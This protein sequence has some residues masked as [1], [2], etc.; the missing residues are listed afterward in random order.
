MSEL[1]GLIF[2]L[3]KNP[4]LIAD[5]DYASAIR[6]ADPNTLA[7]LTQVFCSV[8]LE[9]IGPADIRVHYIPCLGA[10]IK[11]FC[12]ESEAITNLSLGRE[13]LIDRYLELAA[14]ATDE[15]DLRRWLFDFMTLGYTIRTVVTTLESGVAE[16]MSIANFQYNNLHYIESCVYGSDLYMWEVLGDR[17]PSGLFDRIVEAFGEREASSATQYVLGAVWTDYNNGK[18]ERI[19]D[20]AYDLLTFSAIVLPD[21]QNLSICV[22]DALRALGRADELPALTYRV[23]KERF[24]EA[25]DKI[26]ASAVTNLYEDQLLEHLQQFSALREELRRQKCPCADY[27]PHSCPA[28]YRSDARF[29]EYFAAYARLQLA[30][31]KTLQWM[32]HTQPTAIAMLQQ[33]AAYFECDDIPVFLSQ[34]IRVALN[35]YNSLGVTWALDTVER[36]LPMVAW[37]GSCAPDVMTDV[38]RYYYDIGATDKMEDLLCN[39]MLPYFEQCDFS[40][41]S[42]FEDLNSAVITASLLSSLHKDEYAATTENLVTQATQRVERLTNEMDRL[43]IY[44][45]IADYY[46]EIRDYATCIAFLNRVSAHCKDKDFRLWNQLGLF[47]AEYAR[48]AYGAAAR[49]ADRILH[50]FRR[51][52]LVQ[53]AEIMAA[54]TACYART[55]D[56][57]KM[58][59]SADAYLELMTRDIGSR[60]YNLGGEDREALWSKLQH[61]FA[62]ILEAYVPT[63]RDRRGE[64]AIARLFYDWLLISK[65]LLLE[66]DNR[67]DYLLRN[68]PD[69]L[70]RQRYEQMRALRIAIDAGR[71]RDMDPQQLSVQENMLALAR[72]DVMSALRKLN[73]G[74]ETAGPAIR[75]QDVH[76]CLGEH[77]AA[78]EFGSIRRDRDGEDETEYFALVLRSGYAAPR[79]VSLCT[80]RELRQA[81]G[82]LKDARLYA[83]PVATHKHYALLWEPLEEYLVQGDTVCFSVDGQLHLYNMEVLRDAAGSMADERY[84]LRRL[85]STRE[86]C[87]DRNKPPMTHAVLYGALNYRMDNRKLARRADPSNDPQPA[88]ARGS[89]D[90]RVPRTP[91]PETLREV[92]DIARLLRMHRIEADTVLG[93][94]GVEEAFKALSGQNVHIL[95]LATHGFYMEGITA[96]QQTDREL[97]PMMRSGLVLS[98]SETVDPQRREDGLLLA[99]EIADMDLRSVGLVVLS[100]CQTGQGEV[101]DNGVFGLQ[102]GFKQAGV[103]TIVMSLWEVDSAMTQMMM[104]EFYRL[105]IGG[106][107]RHEALRRA[108]AAAR[109]AYPDRDWAAFVMLD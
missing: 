19:A 8:P 36:T 24:G 13:P 11:R 65:G 37:Y 77:R 84:N 103:G 41:D 9:R 55:A 2:R 61:T 71:L 15:Q 4:A 99:H 83:N 23:G 73:D 45:L 17:L 28:E 102:R 79:M 93:D 92:E 34:A 6:D 59:Q 90:N 1:S 29:T 106:M 58:E 57:R 32:D 44:G 51:S 78:V 69:S 42:L 75:W 107:E 25:F 96:Y 62:P 88:S 109:E 85:S 101:T 95:H 89:S 82:R 30:V 50:A 74:S 98:G 70:V 40:Q 12:T 18:Y 22:G 104:T 10:A 48:N 26:Y 3:Q 31:I 81:C 27:L 38:A 49:H 16:S 60:I 91:L 100:A 72:Q 35:A 47:Q 64:P 94:S 21:A 97:S 105:F 87:I 20:N 52:P 33:V 63:M 67:T 66:A 46:Y 86:L 53:D 14:Q 80:D 43:L 54:V 108:R 76:E 5:F 56:R 68:H 39:Y 7:Y